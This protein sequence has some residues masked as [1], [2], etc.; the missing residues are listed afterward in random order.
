MTVVAI[1]GRKGS[2]KDA[3]AKNFLESGFEQVRFADPLKDMIAVIFAYWGY[4]SEMIHRLIDG[5][6]KEKPCEALAGKTPRYAMQTIGTEWRD[7]IDRKLWTNIFH[8]R[9]TA[10][11]APEKVIVTDCRFPH[12][13]EELQPYDGKLIRLNGGPGRTEEGNQHVSETLVDQLQPD[14]EIFNN[15]T[16]EDLA[17]CVSVVRSA[18]ENATS[19]LEEG[20]VP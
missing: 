5:D 19:I 15:G 14:Y 12:E 4:D 9:M 3:S 18:I 11:N 10:P 17:E 1:S 16:L 7:L 13:Q 2:G 20:D 6:L 8:R